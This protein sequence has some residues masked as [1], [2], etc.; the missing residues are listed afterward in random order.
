MGIFVAEIGRPRE[1]CE[2]SS[3]QAKLGLMIAVIVNSMIGARPV[4]TAFQLQISF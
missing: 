1:V 4:F 2:K 3:V